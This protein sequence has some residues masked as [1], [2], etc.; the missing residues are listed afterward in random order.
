[1][2]TSVYNSPYP[3]VFSRDPERSE[4]LDLCLYVHGSQFF[5]NSSSLNFTVLRLLPYVPDP[6]KGSNGKFHSQSFH[7]VK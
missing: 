7:L 2:N 1:M 3:S 6:L 5:P 4:L